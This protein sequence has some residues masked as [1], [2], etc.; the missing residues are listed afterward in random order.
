MGLTQEIV[1]FLCQLILTMCSIRVAQEGIVI[2][3][4]RSLYY[5]I[6]HTYHIGQT[7]LN[8][9]FPALTTT[10]TTT[11]TSIYASIATG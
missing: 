5:N 1:S 11:T 10:T 2:Y 6:D 8:D 3:L 9:Q 4:L 7:D